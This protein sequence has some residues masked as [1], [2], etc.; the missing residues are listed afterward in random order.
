MV[1]TA[2]ERQQWDLAV[3]DDRV[4]LCQEAEHN[5][6]QL[7]SLHGSLFRVRCSAKSCEYS[8]WNH[9]GSPTVPGLESST[10]SV[11]NLAST[12]SGLSDT[13]IPNCPL[14]QSSK[15]RPG[16]HWF[17]EKLPAEELSRIEEWLESSPR[18]DLVLVIG[19]DRSPFVKEAID[20]GAEVAWL[21]YFEKDLPSTGGDWYV[22]GC[23]SE[24]LPYLVQASLQ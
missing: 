12:Y 23:A 20:K 17:G 5:G 18:V 15:L 8:S 16:V 13:D 22:D 9:S 4:E 19:T 21:N 24:T 14:C 2:L 11:G 7:V 3:T 10:S 6:Q 1:C